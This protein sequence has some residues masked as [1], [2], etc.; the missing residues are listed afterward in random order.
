VGED[1]AQTPSS[2]PPRD[3]SAAGSKPGRD[4]SPEYPSNVLTYRRETLL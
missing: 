3:Q 2:P 4:F 1:T